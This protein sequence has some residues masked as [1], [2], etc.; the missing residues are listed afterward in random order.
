MLVTYE[1]EERKKGRKK[2]RKKWKHGKECV[3]SDKIGKTINLSW[4]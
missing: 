3:K 4:K 2:E 1:E